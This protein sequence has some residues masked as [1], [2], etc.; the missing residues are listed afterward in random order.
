M[1]C[2]GGAARRGVGAASPKRCAARRRRGESEARRGA[3]SARRGEVEGWSLT[4]ARGV[5]RGSQSDA[6][7]QR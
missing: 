4:D 6:R 5:R 2:G 1:G 3:A 7:G